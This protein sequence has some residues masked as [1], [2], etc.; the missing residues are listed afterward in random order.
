MTFPLHNFTCISIL[1]KHASCAALYK[2]CWNFSEQGLNNFGK[3]G[4]CAI[5]VTLLC[6][7]PPLMLMAPVRITQ[8]NPYNFHIRETVYLFINCNW[9]VTRWQWLFYM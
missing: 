7:C 4:P 6:E 9:V 8:T 5:P 3:K 2:R 1:R